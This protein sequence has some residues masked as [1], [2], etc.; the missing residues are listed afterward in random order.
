[1]K[2]MIFAAGLGTRLR[3]LTNTVPKAL[4][5]VAGTPL[6]EI[7]IG[8]L[9]AVGVDEIIINIHHHAEQVVNFLKAKQHFNI[10]IE[11]SDESDQL[12]DTGG[13]IKKASWFFNDGQPFFVYNVD[14]ISGTD[15][16]ALFAAHQ[17]NNGLVTLLVRH[18][19]GSRYFL[20][21]DNMQLCGW[22]NTQT[23]EK[24]T[25][26]QPP[27][28]P[29]LLAFSSIHVANPSIFKYMDETGAFSIRDFYLKIARHHAIFGYLDDDTPWIDV[30]T[31]ER[32]KE[33]D[34]VFQKLIR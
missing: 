6:L 19:K 23:G 33:A 13:G 12:L 22:T 2:A 11:I 20:F 4:V 27:Q 1:M 17:L 18:R 10:R 3:P 25:A 5:P 26:F 16:S 15:L 7:A 8:K 32:L 9:K 14:I 21:D 31:P 34:A 24:V 29:S 28:K 30:G